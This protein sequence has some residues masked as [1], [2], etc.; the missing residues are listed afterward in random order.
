MLKWDLEVFKTCIGFA[1]I[2]EESEG[3]SRLRKYRKIVWQ[4]GGSSR[5]IH[6][7]S[8]CVLLDFVFP[9]GVCSHAQVC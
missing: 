4:Y 7:I 1:C 2:D 5:R 9:A 3:E 6:S 8:Q